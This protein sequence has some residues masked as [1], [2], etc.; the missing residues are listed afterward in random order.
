MAEG[1]E[2]DSFLSQ[3]L[4]FSCILLAAAYAIG[5]F[6]HRDWLLIPRM[7]STHGLLNSVGFVLPG[8][9]GWLTEHEMT[10]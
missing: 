3:L 6:F 9:L 7:A 5:D 4:T 2:D 1:T 10:N 8:L